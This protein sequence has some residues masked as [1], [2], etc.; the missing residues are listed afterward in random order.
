MYVHLVRADDGSRARDTGR[1]S[2]AAADRSAGPLWAQVAADL[3]RRITAGEF[4]RAFPGE[5]AVAQDYGVS[6]HTAR[7]A[8][9]PLREE[10]LVQASRG[11]SPR[12]GSTEIEQPL[13]ALYSLFASVE[14]SGRVQTSVVRH[15]EVVVDPDVA[16]RLGRPADEPLLHL[17]RV[18]LQDEEPLAL[19]DVWLPAGRTRPL[20]EA[21][22]GRTA[23][24][25]ELARRCGIRLSGGHEQIR[26]VV[27]DPEESRLLDLPA[28]S[29]ALQVDRL[30]EV[31][32]EPFEWRRTLVRGD[33]LT[34]TASFTPRHGYRWED[35][36]GG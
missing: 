13:G 25:D 5:H 16:R 34:L 27:P 3:R 21:D 19:D 15:L 31:A 12:L 2:P 9:R 30:G 33:R 6:R 18:R 10:G 26:A 23:L 8:L 24:Y 7:A 29:A 36:A 11:R 35:P 32:G 14:A 28:G 20:L 4:D 1:V 17:A 22:F